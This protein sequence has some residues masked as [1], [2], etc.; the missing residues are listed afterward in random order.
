MKRLKVGLTAAVSRV[1]V[2]KAENFQGLKQT[3]A[4]Y[5][6]EGVLQDLFHTDTVPNVA[7]RESL[8]SGWLAHGALLSIRT[9]TP[10]C[11]G[12]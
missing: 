3:L 2:A 11:G 1:A 12:T 4:Q 5:Q 10:C 7:R 9:D 8:W 6:V